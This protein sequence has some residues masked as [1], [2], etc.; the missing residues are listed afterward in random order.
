V[1]VYVWTRL[2][3]MRMCMMYECVYEM[4]YLLLRVCSPSLSISYP[5]ELDAK[6]DKDLSDIKES[7]FK[8]SHNLFKLRKAEADL[9][10][11]ISGAQGTSRNLQS[12]VH[13]LDHRSLKQQVGVLC[14]AVYCVL[15]W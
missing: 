13:G 11:E 10:A 2:S 1:C 15:G 9:I 8:H 3:V 12:K 4:A 14:R 7:G 6:T 5:Q